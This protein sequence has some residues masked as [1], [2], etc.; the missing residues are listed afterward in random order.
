M[1]VSSREEKSCTGDEIGD[2]HGAVNG[3][4]LGGVGIRRGDDTTSSATSLI[5]SASTG[6]TGSAQDVGVVIGIGVGGPRGVVTV[7]VLPSTGTDFAAKGEGTN[8][9]I[10]YKGRD[11]NTITFRFF[12]SFRGYDR[13]NYPG[14][15]EFTGRGVEL[16][17]FKSFKFNGGRRSD[18]LNLREGFPMGVDLCQ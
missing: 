13:V 3:I 7:E 1:G 14:M 5:G 6:F 18:L 17:F 9:F 8:K 15:D 10:Y 12:W 4:C 2:V 11:R 16:F